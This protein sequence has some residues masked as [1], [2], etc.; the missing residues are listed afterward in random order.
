MVEAAKMRD[1]PLEHMLLTGPP[2]TGKTSI[3]AVIANESECKLHE[4]NAPSI[5]SVSDLREILVDLEHRDILFLDEIHGLNSKFEEFLH[6]AMEDFVI[7]IRLGRMIQRIQIEKFCLIGATTMAGRISQPI[8]DRFGLVHNME[9]YRTEELV[10]ILENSAKK[11]EVEVTDEEA[12]QNVAERSRSTPRIAN[13]L[14]R[15]VRDYAQVKNSGLINNQCV[16]AA[17]ELEDVDEHGLTKLDKQYLTVLADTYGG[18]PAG[19]DAIATSLSED[20]KT[21]EETVEPYLLLTQIIAR[22]ARGRQLT[23]DKGWKIVKAKG[24]LH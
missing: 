7:G 1:D 20:T 2:G 22:T 21:I 19:V 18:G 6:T 11:L 16:D 9:Y 10:E 5:N 12:L 8:Y 15:R 23:N 4:F 24:L 14:L 3:S 13:R 17:L